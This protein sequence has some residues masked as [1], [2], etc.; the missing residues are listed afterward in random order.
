MATVILMLEGGGTGREERAA[1][2]VKCMCVKSATS[3]QL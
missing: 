3:R 2:A 1:E